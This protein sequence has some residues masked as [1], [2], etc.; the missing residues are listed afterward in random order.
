MWQREAGGDEGSGEGLRKG[1]GKGGER[2]ER[3]RQGM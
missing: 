1:V 3:V 2:E